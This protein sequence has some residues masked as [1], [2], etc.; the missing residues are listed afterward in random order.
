M[1]YTGKRRRG[2][3]RFQHGTN[4][5]RRGW[6]C[7]CDSDDSGDCRQG[8]CKDGVE[9]LLSGMEANAEELLSGVETGVIVVIVWN[10]REENI[11][12]WSSFGL[13]SK[14][15][16]EAWNNADFF[17]WLYEELRKRDAKCCS[18]SHS[19]KCWWHDLKDCKIEGFT[20]YDDVDIDDSMIKL[21]KIPSGAL[22]FRL[23]W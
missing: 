17:Q 20:P 6:T 13:S 7:V 21:L 3:N 5:R 12:E 19:I 18:S 23:D 16:S 4:S 8:M 22:K 14:D 2:T 11:S 15:L 9:E 10:G 1:G